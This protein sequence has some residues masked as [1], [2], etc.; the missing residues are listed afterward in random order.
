MLPYTTQNNEIEKVSCG[1]H[2]TLALDK[3]KLLW[4]WGMG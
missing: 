2:H 1:M 3:T 4:S